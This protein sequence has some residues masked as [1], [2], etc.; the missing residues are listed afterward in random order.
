MSVESC[1]VVAGLRLLAEGPVATVYAGQWGGAEVAV[2][3]FGEGFDRETTASFDRERKALDSLRAERAI[4]PA[5]GVIALP[6]GRSGVRMELCRGSLAGLLG[7]GKVLAV[8]DALAVGWTVAAALAA[9]HQVG[10]V[11]GGVTPHNVLYRQSGELTLADFGVALRRRFPRDP[12]HTVEYAAPESLREDTLSVTSDLYGLGAVVFAAL[13]GAPPFPRRTGQQPGERILQVLR[14]PVPPLDVPGIP[15][16]LSEVVGRLLA[17]DPADRPQDAVVVAELFERMYRSE[18][19]HNDVEAEFDDFAGTAQAAPPPPPSAL[20]S[21]PVR[22]QG[23]RTLVRTFGGPERS[24]GDKAQRPG[25][26]PAVLAGLGAA[27]AALTVVPVITTLNGS[28][29]QGAA[30]AAATAG[31]SADTST[32]PSSPQ[33]SSPAEPDVNLVLAPPNDQGTQVQLTWSAGA[34]LDFAVVV[35]GERLTTTVLMA[36]RQ[37]TK[38]VP[39]DPARKY[40]FQIRGTDGTHIYSGDPVPIR[41]A[42]CNL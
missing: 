20:P 32:V 33:P 23:G 17:K 11:H 24:R 2:K 6:D 37:H 3:V 8:R 4:L 34:D 15:P 36:G 40:C 5:D 10:V 41:G 27:I 14:D 19:G 12:M 29:D 13:T 9:A 30:P 28:T 18:A 38:A 25:R 31:T 16:G 21:E 35:A 39:V 42:H 7:S 1:E 26:R 22:A